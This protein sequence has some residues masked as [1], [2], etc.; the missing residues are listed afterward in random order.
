MTALRRA[1][2]SGF[3][4]WPRGTSGDTLAESMDIVRST[5]HQHLRSAEK[6]LVEAFLEK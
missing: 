4:E 6:K 1:H 3:Y 2:A 5:Y